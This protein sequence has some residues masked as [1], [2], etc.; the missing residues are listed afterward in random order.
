[1]SN[2]YQQQ[3]EIEGEFLRMESAGL[4]FK[5]A[6]GHW[7]LTEAGHELARAEMAEDFGI[8]APLVRLLDRIRAWWI[9]R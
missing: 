6:D 9:L 5:D 2:R 8:L 3:R 4:A 1:M 7:Q